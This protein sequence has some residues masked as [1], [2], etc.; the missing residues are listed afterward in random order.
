[1]DHPEHVQDHR[2]DPAEAEATE[3]AVPPL[4]SAEEIAAVAGRIGELHRRGAAHESAA[5]VAQAAVTLA[6]E[7]V[8][9]LAGLLRSHGPY[10]AAAYLA[11]ATA[12]GSADQAVGT[13]AELRRAGLVDEA[14]ELFHALW[15]APASALPSL[16]AALERAGQPAD[17]QTLLW[18]WASA[19]PAELAALAVGLSAAGRTGDVRHLLRQAAGRPIGDVV[20][21]VQQLAAPAAGAPAPQLSAVLVRE[22]AGMRSPADLAQLGHALLPQRELYEV[23]LGAV[24]VLEESR[25]RGALAALRSAGLPTEPPTTRARGR[26]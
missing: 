14:S 17:G 2:A 4:R 1:M 8:A 11:R 15:G 9:Q 26:R 10:G 16:L 25:S 7:N 24:A 3:A 18:E 23:L 12:H 21:V 20:A 22:A 5:V 6:P 13:L 19:P